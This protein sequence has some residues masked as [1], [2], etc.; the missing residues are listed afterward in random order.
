M[1]LYIFFPELWVTVAHHQASCFVQVLPPKEIVYKTL[2]QRLPHLT[3]LT[4]SQSS[5][6]HL[7]PSTFTQ[8]PIDP[9]S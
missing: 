1:L 5:S 6:A 4:G 9:I 2:L 3:Q 8:D 7:A